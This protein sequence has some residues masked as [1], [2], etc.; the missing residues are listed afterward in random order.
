MDW[1][2]GSWVLGTQCLFKKKKRFR[3]LFSRMFRIRCIA[4]TKWGYASTFH[5][6]E[7]AIKWSIVIEFPKGKCNS[8]TSHWAKIRLKKCNS[9]KPRRLKS[10][11]AASKGA[12]GVKKKFHK[13]WI[14]AHSVIVVFVRS[15]CAY[16]IY[17]SLGAAH[18]D[19]KNLKNAI[20]R[21]PLKINVFGN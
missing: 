1:I 10:N 16:C 11:G 4:T 7:A 13:K 5:I 8:I 18:W 12:C 9:A 6:L 14:L 15:V 20:F 2:L 21:K 17:L 3:Y 19:K